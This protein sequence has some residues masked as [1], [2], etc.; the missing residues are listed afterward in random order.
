MTRFIC[1]VTILAAAMLITLPAATQDTPAP[2]IKPATSNGMKPTGN[3][4]KPF[5]AGASFFIEEME[6]DLD[7]YLK[8]EI[9]KK[10][11]PIKIAAVINEADF[12]LGGSAVLEKE[13]SWHEGWLT[14]DKDNNVGNIQAV[15]RES[16]E[17]VWASEAGDRSLLWGG[18]K[19]GGIRKVADRLAN[20]LKKAI[21]K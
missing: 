8:A 11:I 9:F 20:N 19:R 21:L 7:G 13:Q 10:K 5:P 18:F 3:T 1:V 12:I 6:D 2:E 15:H 16:G 17:L 14:P 4:K